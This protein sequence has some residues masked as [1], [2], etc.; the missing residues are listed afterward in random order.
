MVTAS[1][2]TVRIEGPGERYI[3]E[4][5]VLALTC[6]VTHRHRRAPAHLLWFRGTE[7]LDYN[8]PRGGVSVQTEK[9][10]S[11][12]LSRLMISAVKTKLDSGEYSCSPTDLPT[13]VVT[14]HVQRGQH[15]AAVHQ[16]V[17][18]GSPFVSSSLLV[19]L[20]AASLPV[21]LLLRDRH[22]WLGQRPWSSNGCG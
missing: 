14:V 15:H 3:Q 10:A 4:G 20:L 19:V 18:D 7:R 12:T 16:S 1:P 17:Y 9:M 21:A 2:P 22:F 6:L 13:A 5:S 8:S 11:R